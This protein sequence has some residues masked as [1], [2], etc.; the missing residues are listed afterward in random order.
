MGLMGLHLP[1]FLNYLSAT[2]N[3]DLAMWEMW[4][5]SIREYEASKILF[6]QVNIHD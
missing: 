6:Y 4:A 5:Y 3:L 2:Q 1:I